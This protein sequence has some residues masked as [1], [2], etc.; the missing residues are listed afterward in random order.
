[1]IATIA[2]VTLVA[3][4]APATTPPSDDTPLDTAEAGCAT[5]APDVEMSLADIGG[6]LHVEMPRT[7][8]DDVV[9]CLLDELL[10]PTWPIFLMGETDPDDGLQHVDA[11][12]GYPFN[13]ELRYDLWW[14]WSPGGRLAL[15]LVGPVG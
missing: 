11:T 1:M 5:V 13:L 9:D 15:I 10:L 7:A 14:R 2:V 12:P 4:V 6:S 8:A 3:L